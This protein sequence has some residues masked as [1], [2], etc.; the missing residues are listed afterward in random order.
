MWNVC[1]VLK[2]SL[3]IRVFSENNATTQC[4]QRLSGL[5]SLSWIVQGQW[6]CWSKV[7]VGEVSMRLVHWR[8]IFQIQNSE[9][10]RIDTQEIS[11]AC[12]V[13]SRGL[14]LVQHKYYVG[15]W[16]SSK[17]FIDEKIQTVISL[18]CQRG[19]ANFVTQNEMVILIGISCN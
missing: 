18:L 5:R 7:C 1:K 3:K 15:R 16:K 9:P 6:G 11:G 4:K 13:G 12:L 14:G 10:M 2:I 17:G 8:Q 19:P